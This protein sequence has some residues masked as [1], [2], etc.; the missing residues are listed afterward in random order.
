MFFFNKGLRVLCIVCVLLLLVGCYNSEQDNAGAAALVARQASVKIEPSAWLVYWDLDNGEKELK[1]ISPRLESLSFFAAYFDSHEKLFVPKALLE[2]HAKLKK[3]GKYVEYLTIVNDQVKPNSS[4]S[5]KNTEILKSVLGTDE[6]MDSHIKEIITLTKAGNFEGVEIDYERIWRD[7]TTKKLF[8]KF[9]ERLYGVTQAQGLKLRVVLEPGTPFSTT[10]FI[11]GP[12][13]VVMLYNLYGTH[14][15][16]PGPKAD[17][18]FIQKTL[19]SMETLP[20]PK[21]VA[22]S[23]GG[24]LWNTKGQRRLLTEKEASVIIKKYN[25]QPIRDAE[26]QCL[27]LKY[28]DGIVFNYVWFADVTTINYWISLAKEGGIKNVALWRLGGNS[29]IEN[30]K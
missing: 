29:S 1:K 14:T 6:A 17:R 20:E 8:M 23:G 27:V 21:T 11:T 7:A 30:I 26:S 15:L 28:R 4:P 19:T 22:Y 13:Y 2:K 24:C 25:L 3:Q 12:E 9:I 5:V 10:H 16:L 18:T